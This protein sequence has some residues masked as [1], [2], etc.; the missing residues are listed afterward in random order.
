[1]A[2]QTQMPLQILKAGEIREFPAR[3][4]RPAQKVRTL[5]C[6]TGDVVGTIRHYIREDGVDIV[7][8]GHYMATV[9]WSNYQGDLTPRVVGLTPRK[10]VNAE[11]VQK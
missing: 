4:G 2:A 7:D 11:Q 8:A 3:D 10:N 9:E 5:Q 1:M 6:F